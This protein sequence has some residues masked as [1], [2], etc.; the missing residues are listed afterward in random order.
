MVEFGT[1]VDAKITARFPRTAFL[2]ALD[3]IDPREWAA[4]HDR[5]SAFSIPLTL[6]LL[7][8]THN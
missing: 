6:Y 3:V 2:A 8:E 5:N 4:A 7:I 1:L